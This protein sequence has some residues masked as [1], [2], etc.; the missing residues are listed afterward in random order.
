[1]IKIRLDPTL[2]STDPIL[3]IPNTDPIL[4]LKFVRIHNDFKFWLYFQTFSCRYCYRYYQYQ[5]SCS[6]TD[7]PF[8]APIQPIPIPG[9]GASLQDTRSSNISY[10]SP[11]FVGIIWFLTSKE[12]LLL[13]EI[14]LFLDRQ[15]FWNDFEFCDLGTSPKASDVVS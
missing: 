5:Y 2:P 4:T 13:F 6:F 9:I 3:L 10:T 7:T 12:K 14:K 8:L 1:M 11:V 15:T